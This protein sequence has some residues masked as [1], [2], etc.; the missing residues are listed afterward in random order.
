MKRAAPLNRLKG[1]KEL[2]MFV[3][4]RILCW[5]SCGAAS[6]VAT[7]VTLETYGPSNEV[8]PVYCDT[9]ES[10]H[11]DNL[12]FIADCERW[13][14]VP[15]TRIKHP[16]YSTVEE[17]FAAKRYMAGISGAC[18]T[19]ALK[20]LPRF[21]FQAPNDLHVF[22]FTSDE[23]GR[24]LD[25]EIRNFELRLFWILRDRGITKQDCY[26]RLIEAGI[27]LPEMYRLGYRNNN[28]IGCVKATSPGYWSKVREDFPDKFAERARQ[29][30]EVGCRL[31]RVNGK[32]IFLDELPD[33]AFPYKREN[34]S[35][36]PECGRK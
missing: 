20:K 14:G 26:A 13:F 1:Q 35:C 11:P 24:R 15:V 32:R 17:V 31:V 2:P 9:S 6:A 21:V 8:L 28:C 23:M 4:Q 33:H 36:G 30:R 7:K 19:A 3:G 12:R 10:E 27:Q 5:F 29:S 16:D 22:G 34:L 18:C 25:F